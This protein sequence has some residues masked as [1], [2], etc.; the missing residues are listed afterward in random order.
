MGRQKWNKKNSILHFKF[1]FAKNFMY[2]IDTIFIHRYRG[3]Y[4][5]CKVVYLEKVRTISK[6]VHGDNIKNRNNNGK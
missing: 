6:E 5:V 4:C 1:L 3:I 2:I